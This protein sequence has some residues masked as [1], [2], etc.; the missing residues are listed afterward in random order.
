MID[1]GIVG[2]FLDRNPFQEF[3]NEVEPGNAAP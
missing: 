3:A 2:M 1:H